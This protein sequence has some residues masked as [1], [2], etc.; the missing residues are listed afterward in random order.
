MEEL[1]AGVALPQSRLRRR[2][3][4][5]AMIDRA[6]IRRA[7]DNEQDFHF[8]HDGLVCR[9]ELTPPVRLLLRL[10]LDEMA[11]VEGERDEATHI[12]AAADDPA[13]GH[14]SV[15]TNYKVLRAAL[16]DA[17]AGHA[18]AT[19]AL[20]NARAERDALNDAA[21]VLGADFT[22]GL[23]EARA[24]TEAAER[25]RGALTRLLDFC[26]EYAGMNHSDVCDC[27]L[28]QGIALARAALAA[29]A[30]SSSLRGSGDLMGKA[31]GRSE[32]G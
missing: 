20:S 11:R 3:V 31:L 21:R 23:Q 10:L 29:P 27:G 13:L 17:R 26:T 24:A 7:L 22:R 18:A 32:G 6:A 14:L 19:E 9:V 4:E 8:E 25:L 28:C 16:S 12:I 5:Y 15:V 30:S 1:G 2:H